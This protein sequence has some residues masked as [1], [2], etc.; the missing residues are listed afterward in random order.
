MINNVGIIGCG[1]YLPDLIVSNYEIAK[2]FEKTESWIEER[3][4]IR[5]RRKAG[6]G[7]ATSDMAI[8]AANVA[9]K[10]ANILPEEVDLI[11]VATTTPDMVFPSTACL[12]QN[13]IGACNA[14]ALDISAACTGFMY[15][16]DMAVSYVMSGRY[17]KILLIGADTYSRITNQNDLQTSILFGDGAGAVVISEVPDGF[18]VI[19]SVLGADGS[20]E[21]LLQ[22]PAGGSRLPIT[23]DILNKNLNTIVMNGREVFQFAVRKFEEVTE[24]ILQKSGLNLEDISL[25]IPH[26]ANKRILQS[27][28]GRLNIPLNKIYC[29]IEKYGN[30]SSASIPVALSEAC[31][32]NQVEKGDLLLLIGFGAGLTWGASIIKWYN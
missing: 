30:M 26:Q 28:A 10:K 7:I 19:D 20:G 13:G 15:G 25:I 3:T 2:R 27:V 11:I 9:I 23:H 4:G 6:N 29:N 16:L 22:V 32:N 17:K 24:Q 21:N 12:V 8:K 31:K 1:H 18:G 5:E 14:A